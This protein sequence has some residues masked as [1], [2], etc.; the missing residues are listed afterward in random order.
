MAF[1]IWEGVCLVLALGVGAGEEGEVEVFIAAA[2]VPGTDA[3]GEGL[4]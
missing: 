1:W 4:L 2:G 3:W